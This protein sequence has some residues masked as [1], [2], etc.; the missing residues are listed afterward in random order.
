MSEE[1]EMALL[2]GK[3]AVITGAGSGIGEATAVAMAAHGAKVLVSDID[4]AAAASVA[5]KLRAKGADA[6]SIRTDVTNEL[7][8]K[9]MIEA[10]KTQWGGIDILYNNAGIMPMSTVP[11]MS[12]DLWDKVIDIS[13]KGTFLCCKFAIPAME[14]Q[15]SGVIINAS[16]GAAL[17]GNS[18]LAAYGAAKAGIITLTKCMA[19]DHSPNGVRVNCICP[20]AID[21]E[22]NQSWIREAEDPAQARSDLNA[23]HLMKRMGER[24]EVAELVCF[25]ASDLCSYMTGSAIVFDGGLT[26]MGSR[27]A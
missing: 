6:F 18:A 16:S 15:G 14:A 13:L 9:R 27:L 4:E 3:R 19:V 24:S 26:V 12:E 20:G 1:V 22:M 7:D 23:S 11:D 10:V 17:V 5:T 21:T 8:C 25:L 2:E